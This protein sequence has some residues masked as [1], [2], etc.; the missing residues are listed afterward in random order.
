MHYQFDNEVVL[1]DEAIPFMIRKIS[2]A[3]YK[4]IYAHGIQRFQCRELKNALSELDSSLLYSISQ[5]NKKNK[6]YYGKFMGFFDIEGKRFFFMKI[7]FDTTTSEKEWETWLVPKE[8]TRRINAITHD[9]D[10]RSRS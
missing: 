3:E 8:Y 7:F 4:Y 1:N 6:A 2:G 10:D 9:F 5:R